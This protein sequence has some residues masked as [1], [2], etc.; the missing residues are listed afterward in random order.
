M[1]IPADLKIPINGMEKYLI[2]RAFEVVEPNLL[3]KDVLWRRK[4]AFS[5]GVSKHVKSWF[6]IIQE[7]VNEIVTNE[8]YYENKNNYKGLQPVSKESYYFR[9]IYDSNYKD[10]ENIIDYYWLPKWSGNII[11]PSARVLKVYE[12]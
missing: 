11:E 5:D 10:R 12:K 6:E 2:R 8:E 1:K 3:C 7:R 9:K 4:E